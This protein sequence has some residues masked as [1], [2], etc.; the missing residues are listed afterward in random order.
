MK[1]YTIG[2]AG[3]AL[4][5]FIVN[6]ISQDEYESESEDEEDCDDYWCDSDDE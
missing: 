5:G 4:D 2:I 6:E 3:Y 1:N